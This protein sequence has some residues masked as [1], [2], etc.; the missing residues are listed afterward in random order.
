MIC[1]SVTYHLRIRTNKKTNLQKYSAIWNYVTHHRYWAYIL[2]QVD[3]CGLAV[4]ENLQTI[5]Y[6]RNI[7]QLYI[8]TM[9]EQKTTTIWR[10]YILYY[11][12]KHV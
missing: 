8:R 5:L 4:E 3:A 12:Y 10:W 2:R 9:L 11:T 1:V 7:T 6:T